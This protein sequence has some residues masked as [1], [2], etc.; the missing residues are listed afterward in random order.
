MASSK[1]LADLTVAEVTAW[2]VSVRLNNAF[3]NEFVEQQIDG[4]CLMDAED[5]DFDRSGLCFTKANVSAFHT[6]Y[7]PTM[8]VQTL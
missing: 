5:S 8:Y 2:L 6:Q 7:M 1:S 4:E 3:S